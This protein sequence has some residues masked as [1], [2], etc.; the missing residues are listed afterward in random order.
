MLPWLV[1]WHPPSEILK[2]AI[3]N[4]P[5]RYPKC[6]EQ[7]RIQNYP[8]TYPWPVGSQTSLNKST[9]DGS[10]Q[11]PPFTV[12]SI[13]FHRFSIVFHRFSIFFH[14]FSYD[15]MG[16]SGAPISTGRGAP[17]RGI[18]FSWCSSNYNKWYGDMIMAIWYDYNRDNIM[19]YHQ[20]SSTT[21]W[22]LTNPS[23]KYERVK[24]YIHPIW[25]VVLSHPSEKWSESQLRFWYSQ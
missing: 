17:V 4:A 18:A 22:W 24:I 20:H 7:L 6:S 2:M 10:S 21:G 11:P 14:R 16:I 15:F 1:I 8:V 9:I 13:V 12:F 19:V 3:R 23:E 25:L 5:N